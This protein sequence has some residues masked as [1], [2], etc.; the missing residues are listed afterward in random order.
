MLR[1]LSEG[2]VPVVPLPVAEL[3]EPLLPIVPDCPEAPVV[4]DCAVAPVDPAPLLACAKIAKGHAP[5]AAMTAVATIDLARFMQ[6]LLLTTFVF[7]TRVPGYAV[8]AHDAVMAIKGPSNRDFDG[9]VG[10]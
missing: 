8:R 6:L 5:H 2:D 9:A 7:L 3:S 4:P 1:T 10:L